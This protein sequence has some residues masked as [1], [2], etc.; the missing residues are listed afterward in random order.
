VAQYTAFVPISMKI[1]AD[2]ASSFIADRSDAASRQLAWAAF[3]AA[4]LPTTS[5]EVWRYAPSR[6]STSTGSAWSPNRRP[7]DSAFASQLCERAGLVVRVVDGFCVDAGVARGR[8]RRVVESANSLAGDDASP[9][10]TA[11]T[12]SRCSTPRSPRRRR[13][14]ASAPGVLVEEPIVV[15]NVSNSTASF[16]R[17]QIELGRGASA[18]IVEYF[19][20]GADALVVP[21][22]EYRSSDN[23][24]LQLITY[25]RLDQSAWHVARTTGFLSRD[26]R[27]RQAVVGI[28]AH[29][30]RSRNDAEMRG[31]GSENELRTT[32]L[33]S[34]TRCTTFAPT[35]CTPAARSALD[36][37]LQG[38]GRRRLALGLHRTDRDRKGRQA[39][40]R[41]TDE[42]QPP[43]LTGGPR[44]QRAQP[45]HPRE[46]RHVRARLERRTARRAAALVPRV[47]R[48]ER[49]D[50]ERLMIQ[51]FFNEMLA[52]LPPELAELVERDVTSVLATVNVVTP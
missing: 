13:S 19:E 18:T 30:N 16:P 10:A 4:G 3:E 47:A 37:A 5:D 6:T 11:T 17:T 32:F 50:A 7:A 8:H 42:P 49:E 1:F 35:R 51:G 2:S 20:G 31:A 14:S 38:R 39:H 15:L 24:S 25:Q 22:S 36:A 43:A 26:A 52:N 40:R 21:L 48:G 34:G 46:R 45:G 33:G 9:I 44:R 27:L 29:Y 28:G 23:A 41:A 12:P